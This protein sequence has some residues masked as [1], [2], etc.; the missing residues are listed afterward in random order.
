MASQGW[1]KDKYQG[2]S[3]LWGLQKKEVWE[4]YSR[5]LFDHGLVDEMLD[6]DSAFTNKFV[7]EDEE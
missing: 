6:V 4:N 5:W 1:L 7:L 3:E 2:E